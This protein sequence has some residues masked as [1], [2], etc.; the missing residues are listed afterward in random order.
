MDVFLLPS[1]FEGL[2]IVG[3]E[4]QVSGLP[5]FFSRNITDEIKISPDCFFLPLKKSANYWA[6][7]ILKNISLVRAALP[8]EYW[9]EKLDL[10]RGNG[11]ARQVLSLI[12]REL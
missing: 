8:Q 12:Q 3:V 4:A 11:P 1:K 9:I 2:P 5:C 10:N 7:F 6:S